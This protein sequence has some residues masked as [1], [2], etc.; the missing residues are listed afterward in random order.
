V[1]CEPLTMSDTLRIHLL[2]YLFLRLKVTRWH[3]QDG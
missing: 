2:H 3:R 1:F